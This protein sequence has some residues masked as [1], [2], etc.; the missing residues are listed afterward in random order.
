MVSDV[1][2]GL[3]TKKIITVRWA[4]F[5]SMQPSLGLDVLMGTR[6]VDDIRKVLKD[7]TCVHLN[8][9]FA[10][11]HG[12]IGWQT[13]GRIPIRVKGDGTI[14]L[15]VTDD[16][17]DWSGW[18]PYEEMPQSY[19]PARGWV[20]TAN[21]NTVKADY[22]YYYSSWFA[23]SYRYQRI[24]EI[25]DTPEKKSVDD[26]W[27]YM[28]DDLNVSAR[29]NAPIFAKALSAL[30]ETKELGEILSKWD[31]KESIDSAAASIYQETYRNLA[32]LVFKDELGEEL[33]TLMIGKNY[34][35]QER[36]GMM[37]LSGESQWFDDITT[38]DKKENLTDLIQRAG[39]ATIADLSERIGK[40]PS[41][42]QWGKIHQIEFLNPLRRSGLGKGWLGGG[43][44]PMA[45]SGDTVY[46]AL[47]PLNH[48]GNVV[49]YSAALRMVADL[50]DNEKVIA[51]IP[52]GVVGRTFSPHFTDQIKAY[53][54]GEK[55][56]WWFSDEKIKE[57]AQA[58]LVLNP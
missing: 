4:P 46:R 28:R 20:G 15:L 27:K 17:D 56:Y 29:T 7:L 42:W 5:E 22:P 38:P 16:V 2:K 13:T 58:E 52:G 34:Y 9:V 48:E 19:R 31:F 8:Y 23:P 44:H 49:K 50:S 11:V 47:F 3:K 14:P 43:S 57:H 10:D 33:G 6:S 51:V 12:G 54:S 25:L 24:T 30:P 18:I 39:T 26:H 37:I 45:G 41:K 32:G 53:M 21:H 1:L 35:W 55:M 40:D 36:L